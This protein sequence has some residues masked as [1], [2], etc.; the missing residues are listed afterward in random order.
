MFSQIAVFLID[1]IVTFVVFLLLAR[2]HFQWLRVPFRNPVGEFV[3]VGTNW[4]VMPARRVIPGLGGLDLA[5]LL[6]AWLAQT[7]GLWAQIAVAGGQPALGPIL[8]VAAVDL[9]RYSLY[10]LVFAVI[11]QAVLSW[12]NPYTPFA[13]VFDALTRPFLRPIRRFVPLLGQFDI[14]PLILLIVLQVILIP[15]GHL[16]AAA[17]TI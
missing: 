12:V 11:V 8:A 13:P 15:I 2:F 1:T 10:L 7:A 9:L 3:L 16:R 6:L 17:A 14:S 4:A 5:S